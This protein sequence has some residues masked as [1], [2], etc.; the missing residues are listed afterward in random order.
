MPC[1]L[2]NLQLTLSERGVRHVCCM[3]FLDFGKVEVEER[4]K[5]K[6]CVGSCGGVQSK[7]G[8]C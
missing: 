1:I 8:S 7:D 6:K 4:N 5:E 2:K 3:K